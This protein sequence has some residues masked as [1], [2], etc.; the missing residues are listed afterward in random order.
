M[1]CVE[2]VKHG[3]I[4]LSEVRARG[5]NMENVL[6]S[7][8]GRCSGKKAEEEAFLFFLFLLLFFFFKSTSPLKKGTLT[9]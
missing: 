4:H 8:A 9:Q 7:A 5:G 2:W 3:E 6:D 1:G